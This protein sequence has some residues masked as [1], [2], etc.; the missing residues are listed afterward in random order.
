MPGF[1]TTVRATAHKL[2]F[3]HQLP[4]LTLLGRSLLLVVAELLVNAVFWAVAGILFGKN[5]TRSILGL[6]LLAWVRFICDER[7]ACLLIYT[8]PDSRPTTW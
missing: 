8:Q 1:A 6:A 4:R 2:A 5:D 7:S 3:W